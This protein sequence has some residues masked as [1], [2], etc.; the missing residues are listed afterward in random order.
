M[1]I[2]LYS[3]FLTLGPISSILYVVLIFACIISSLYYK[4]E[5]GSSVS[6]IEFIEYFW[7]ETLYI[8]EA[9]QFIEIL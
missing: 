5:Y 1:M 8:I 2:W 4:L 6:I 3:V 9:Y 7:L